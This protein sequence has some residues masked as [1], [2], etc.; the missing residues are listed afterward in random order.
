[1]YRLQVLC[2]EKFIQQQ[3]L[4]FER[5]QSLLI[6]QSQPQNDDLEDSSSSEEKSAKLFRLATRKETSVSESSLFEVYSSF[7]KALE[8]MKGTAQNDQQCTKSR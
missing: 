5:E 6:L 1:M 2:L 7:E 4:Q 8:H 3:N